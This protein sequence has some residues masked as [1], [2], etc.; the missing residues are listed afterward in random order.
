MGLLS[1]LFGFGGGL[2]DSLF[3]GSDGMGNMGTPIPPMTKPQSVLPQT[4]DMNPG[5]AVD[6]YSAWRSPGEKFQQTTGMPT[7]PSKIPSD[8]SS[9]GQ[10]RIPDFGN[11]QS[12]P[13]NA[14]GPADS[15]FP[16][17]GTPKQPSQ[18]LLQSQI[19]A[20]PNQL[21]QNQS[22]VAPIPNGYGPA[23]TDNQPL[24]PAPQFK[25]DFNIP[26][27]MEPNIWKDMS[28][29]KFRPASKKTKMLQENRF[30]R[31]LRSIGFDE[32]ADTDINKDT[33]ILGYNSKK[34]TK[35]FESSED[36]LAKKFPNQRASS[37]DELGSVSAQQESGGR[38]D[39]ISSGIGDKGGRSYGKYQLASATGTVQNFIKQ[40]NYA[41]QFADMKINSKQFMNKWKELSRDPDFQKSQFDYIKKTHYNPV[42]S[43]ADDLGIPNNRAINEALFSMGVQHGGAAKIV[44]TAGIKQG[45]DIPTIVN[46]LYDRRIQYVN[47]LKIQNKKAILNRF[48]EEREHLL[49]MI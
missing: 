34:T 25:P 38:A 9:V 48:K 35:S 3:G 17:G 22:K 45:D 44:K 36:I 28:G 1:G 30:Q 10:S 29:L 5:N 2:F 24:H 20:V 15:I 16:T 23:V 43:V 4:P 12:N 11:S 13:A 21:D 32:S 47:R 31:A 6:P 26:Y 37:A 41:D 8:P 40:S 42:R 27:G 39:S 14:R 18:G 46:K 7:Q 49:E 33:D 19:P